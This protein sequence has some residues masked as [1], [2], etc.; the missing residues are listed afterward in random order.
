MTHNFIPRFAAVHQVS[1]QDGVFR[2]RQ[3]AGGYF[4]GALLDGDSL[5]VLIHSLRE[6]WLDVNGKFNSIKYNSM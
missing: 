3:T 1:Q 4:T 6:R 2:P 5:I